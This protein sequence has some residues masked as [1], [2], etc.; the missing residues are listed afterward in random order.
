MS[1]ISATVRG[2]EEGVRAALPLGEMVPPLE[3]ANLV[4]FVSSGLCRHMT[5]ATLDI[6][7]AAYVR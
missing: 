4:A 3:V 6:N 5:G 1:Q 7:G 2:G